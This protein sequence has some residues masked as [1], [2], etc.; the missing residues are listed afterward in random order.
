MALSSD[1]IAILL[2]IGVAIAI[3]FCTVVV[4]ALAMMPVI[5]FV[6]SKNL[7]AVSCF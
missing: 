5:H 6:R 1:Q 3:T 2:P 7:V 4:H